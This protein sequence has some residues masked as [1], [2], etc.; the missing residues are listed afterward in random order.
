MSAAKSI[1]LLRQLESA[2]SASDMKRLA[3]VVREALEDLDKR[4]RELEDKSR[5]DIPRR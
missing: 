2:E 1:A 5:S 3:K 4:L